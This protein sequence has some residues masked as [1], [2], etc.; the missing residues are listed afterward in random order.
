M[1][2]ILTWNIQN[3]KGIDEKISLNRISH[4]ILNICDP[5][6]ICLQEVSINCQLVDGTRP[7]QVDELSNIFSDYLPFYGPAYDIQSKDSNDRE[8]YGNLIL[9]RLPV[10][11][12]FNHMLPQTVNSS[13]RQMP[14]Q[15]SEITV[16]TAL[17]PL[18]VMTTHLEYHSELQR[19]EQVKRI[20]SINKEIND[21]VLMPPEQIINSPYRE[22]QRASRAVICGD[23]NF[24]PDS[25]EYN[26]MTGIED[27]TE[28]LIDASRLLNP[29]SIHSPTCGIFDVD[30][31]PQGPHCRDYGFISSNL[32]DNIQSIVVNEKIDASDH[33]PVVITLS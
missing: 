28:L 26:L 24:V 21:L 7:N 29:N 23:F 9:S 5:D 14:R 1:I 15:L 31:W 10:L 33:Q 19:C 13:F 6:I 4:S 17:F 2:K 27:N 18:R 30:Q 11:S 25:I 20:K 3:G 12:S 8:Q 32:T 16:Q 22:F